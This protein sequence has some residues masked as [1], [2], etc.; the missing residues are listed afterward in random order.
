MRREGALEA[1]LGRCPARQPARAARRAYAGAM[2]RALPGVVVV[3]LVGLVACGG[4]GGGGRGRASSPRPAA[5]GPVC[6][7]AVAI[8]DL[9][10]VIEDTRE[11]P[12]IQRKL[13]AR[14]STLQAQLDRR[15]A[16]LVKQRDELEREAKVLAPD[17]VQ[18]KMEAYQL[19]LADLQRDYLRSQESLQRYEAELVGEARERVRQFVREQATDLAADYGLL[20]IYAKR[21]PLWIKPGV[22]PADRAL[23][24]RARFEITDLVIERYEREGRT[25]HEESI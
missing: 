13:K 24:G 25:P 11:R 22:D 18:K 8:V 15:Q 19:A 16:E 4:A 17:V 6:G 7:T 23:A 1:Y 20:A 14:F 10:A 2:R 12:E 5:S 9:D 21:A 3:S